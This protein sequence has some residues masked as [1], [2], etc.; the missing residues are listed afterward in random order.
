MRMSY[1]KTLIA[2]GIAAVLSGCGS[3]IKTYYK[4]HSLKGLDV[5]VEYVTTDSGEMARKLSVGIYDTLFNAK[6]P[7]SSQLIVKR[8]N[9]ST[10]FNEMYLSP[11]CSPAARELSFKDVESALEEMTFREDM[12]R[13]NSMH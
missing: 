1:Y 9:G 8:G 3:N 4:L 13:L 7:F 6:N 12:K 11:Y 2:V 5:Q 10:E